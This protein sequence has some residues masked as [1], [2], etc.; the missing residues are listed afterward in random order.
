VAASLLL[1]IFSF[2]YWSLSFLATIRQP[3]R[4]G[5]R[6]VL[7]WL[8]ADKAGGYV[9]DGG[10]AGAF[11]GGGSIEDSDGVEVDGFDLAEGEDFS[12]GVHEG[13]D[14]ADGEVFHRDLAY[15][16]EV[17]G[18]KD[19]GDDADA[20]LRVLA[21]IGVAEFSELGVGDGR[22]GGFFLVVAGGER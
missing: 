22:S 4:I 8:L 1:P 17:G 14:V 11:V 2:E 15:G 9:A 20:S 10:G 13:D 18:F 6:E 12:V 21:V 19:S 16:G 7:K 3:R 5:S